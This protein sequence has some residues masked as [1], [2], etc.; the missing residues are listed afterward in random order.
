M[1]SILRNYK[2]IPNLLRQLVFIDEKVFIDNFTGY[3]YFEY[4]S[5]LITR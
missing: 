5:M 2:N 4:N 1:Y 3:L